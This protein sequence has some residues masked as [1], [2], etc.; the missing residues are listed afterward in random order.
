MGGV[1]KS[2]LK[3]DCIVLTEITVFIG[4]PSRR[5]VVGE[6]RQ[7]KRQNVRSLDSQ[8]PLTS[9][10]LDEHLMHSSLVALLPLML[11]YIV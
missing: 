6:E 8:A 7:K 4:S 10:A 9:C 1:L 2:V 11:M 5:S 3:S